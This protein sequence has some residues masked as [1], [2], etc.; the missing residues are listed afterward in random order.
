MDLT[1]GSDYS[2]MKLAL[3]T[4]TLLLTVA[5]LGA[6]H[7]AIQIWVRSQRVTPHMEKNVGVYSMLLT[8]GT[9]LVLMLRHLNYVASLDTLPS[10]TTVSMQ[11]W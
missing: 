1:L 2:T 5:L 3:S 8:G 4:A 6:V 10:G 7:T 9:S 11:I